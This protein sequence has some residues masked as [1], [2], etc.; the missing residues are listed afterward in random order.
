MDVVKVG[1]LSLQIS[2]AMIYFAYPPLI[3][4]K[5]F[6]TGSCPYFRSSDHTVKWPLAVS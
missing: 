5:Q 4:S 3:R 2:V 1:S 6:L